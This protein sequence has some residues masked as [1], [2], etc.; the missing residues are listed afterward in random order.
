MSEHNQQRE[1]FYG[2]IFDLNLLIV[3]QNKKAL[4]CI[5]HKTAIYVIK[6]F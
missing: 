5:Y 1:I 2:S 3:D 6:S 4:A